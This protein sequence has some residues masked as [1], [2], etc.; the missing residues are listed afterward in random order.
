[1]PD[2][3]LADTVSRLRKS[4]KA[5]L[6]ELFELHYNSICAAMFRYIKD[7]ALVEDLAQNVFIR[8]WEK[9]QQIEIN[10]S[11]AAYLRRMAINEALG[12]IRKQK[13][14]EEEL[15]PNLNTKLDQSVEEQYLHGELQ[16]NITKAIDSLPPKCRL[17]FQMS[18][19]EELSYREIAER[20]E[21][22]IK[23]VENQMSKALKILRAKLK[24][25][26]K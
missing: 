25:Y 17:V 19:Y 26:L 21:I 5:V 7:R 1:M 18:R 13:Y 14:F 12:H 11:I 15:D 9:R 8:F 16:D 3:D 2:L 23:T 4:D 10:S 22:S 6:R 24:G 20:L